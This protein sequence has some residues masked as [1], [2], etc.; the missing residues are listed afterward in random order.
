MVF[1][2]NKQNGKNGR[3]AFAADAVRLSETAGLTADGL[4]SLAR[5]NE[6]QST[7]IENAIATATEIA[8]SLRAT[9]E[10][11]ESVSTSGE[12][13]AS[14]VNE[15][16]ASIEQITAGATNLSSAVA[17]TGVSFR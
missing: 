9:A 2:F 16:A 1:S 5:T 10:Q 4:A 7:S 3:T 8:T 17:Q 13:L 15:L 14:S 6:T 11:A 12:E